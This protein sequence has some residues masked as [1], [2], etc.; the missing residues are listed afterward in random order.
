MR[1]LFTKTVS[2]CVAGAA[3]C[4]VAAHADNHRDVPRQFDRVIVIVMENWRFEEIDFDSGATARLMPFIIQ[5]ARTYRLETNY[6]GIAHPSLPN[7]IAMIGGDDFGIQDD[8]ES[9]FNPEHRTPCNS[10]DAPNLVDQLE[11][12]GISW[13]GLFESMPNAGYLGARFPEDVK[14]YAQKH[15]PFVYFQNIALNPSRLAKLKPFA[16]SQ[17]KTVLGDPA[18]APRFTYIV[19]N[20]CDSQHGVKGCKSDATLQ[21][22]DAFL[23]RSV[24]TIINS[25]SFT[26]RSV[27]F[28]VWDEGRG[29]AGCCGDA[30]G[31]RVPV[32]VV[33]KHPKAIKGATPSNHYSLLATIEDGFGLPRLANAQK[34]ATLFDV[35]PFAEQMH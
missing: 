18:S 10:V 9:C 8:K 32:I 14:L 31:G 4:I 7:Y 12:E 20:Q 15:N 16:L 19:P 5:L 24:P 6:F 21:A 29:H 34:A 28:I 26:D 13:E 2:L 22:G 27:L 33:S 1:G 35:L 17:L 25:P 3:A 23:S 11:Q 30:G